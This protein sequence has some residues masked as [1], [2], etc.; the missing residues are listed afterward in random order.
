M[1]IRNSVP[2]LSEHLA[3]NLGELSL[4]HQTYG[5]WWMASSDDRNAAGGWE[6]RLVKVCNENTGG[7]IALVSGSA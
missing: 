4:F 3:G 6:E 7:A 5:I 2:D 1:C